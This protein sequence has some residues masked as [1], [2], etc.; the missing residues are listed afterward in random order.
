MLNVNEITLHV[1]LVAKQVESLGYTTYVFEDLNQ[2]DPDFRFI[3][4]TE[5]PN[6]SGYK[7]DIGDIGYVNL[8]YIKAGVDKWFNGQTF[9]A[10]NYSNVQFLKFALESKPDDSPLVL[11]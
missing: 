8:R 5:F 1:K 3:M 10:Y 9:I 7:P 6:W 4:C 2:R 11:D